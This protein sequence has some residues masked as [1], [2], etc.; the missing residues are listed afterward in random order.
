MADASTFKGVPAV[1]S[2]AAL[3]E[4]VVG[5]RLLKDELA[6][7][8]A[9]LRAS[10]LDANAR[11]MGA[12]VEER[13]LSLAPHGK[14]TMSPELIRRQLDGGAWGITAATA[15][16]VRLYAAW[17]VPRILLANQLVGAANLSVVM[18]ELRERPA[19]EFLCLVDSLEGVAALAAAARDHG[20]PRPI[21]VLVE[22]GGAGER[23]G[24]RTAEAALE[25]AR[26]CALASDRIA[27]RG[28]ECFEGVHADVA[29]A[30]RLLARL[31]G[32]AEGVDREGL[33]APGEAIVS[34]GGTAF[35]DRAAAAM[36]GVA[37]GRPVRRVLRSGCY[38]VHDSGT[39]ERSHAAAVA[40]EPSLGQLGPPQAA[41]EVW[42]HVQSRPEPRRV[43]VSV[44]K[45][46]VGTDAEMPRPLWTA[47]PDRDMAPVPAASGISVAKI[48]DQHVCLDVPSDLGLA[49][50]D[51]VGFGIAHPCTTFD[52]W[53]AMFVV[54]DSYCVTDVV[55]TF[56]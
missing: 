5:R 45:R 20:I 17:G 56:F 21:Q 16:H 11:W 44:G 48:Y 24:A 33:L 47:R 53:R 18:R 23:T 31:I 15:H 52:K 32:V 8:A 35:F 27:L 49:V 6:L 40:R 7:P 19:L 2:E 54:D 50:G 12:F 29:D 55:H 22:L 51:L 4:S 26:A 3:Q 34:A 39:Y 42:G 9:V 14:T 13:R 36:L 28:V 38:L 41:L 10:A 43:V 37:F 46:D 1:A 30:D 25:V